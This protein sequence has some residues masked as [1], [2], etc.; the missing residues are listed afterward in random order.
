MT[1]VGKFRVGRWEFV[2]PGIYPVEKGHAHMN[3]VLAGTSAWAAISPA[4]P[5]LCVLYA[6]SYA[7]FC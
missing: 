7:V 2:H 4:S 6:A 5:P 3:T 1:R